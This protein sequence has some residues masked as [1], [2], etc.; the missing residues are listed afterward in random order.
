MK[1]LRLFFFATIPALMIAC[2]EGGGNNT[3]KSRDNNNQDQDRNNK[4]MNRGE[5]G[6]DTVS[7]GSLMIRFNKAEQDNDQDF[8]KEAASSGLMEIELGRLAEQNASNPRVKK[9]GAMMVRDHTKGSEE[10]KSIAKGKNIEVPTEMDQKHQDMVEDL[11]NENG[12]EFDEAYIKAMVTAHDKDINLYE[13]QSEDG[14][15]AELK[16]YASK[17]LPV[18]MMHRDSVKAIQKDLK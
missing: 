16:S 15:V 13:K 2:N 4:E 7:Q 1:N 18:L 3:N 6:S 12:E 8:V 5:T 14:T 11:R 17:T 9:F 10:L